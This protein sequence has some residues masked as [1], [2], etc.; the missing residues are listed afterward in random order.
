[1]EDA[2]YYSNLVQ[3]TESVQHQS[4]VI[5]RHVYTKENHDSDF[6]YSVSK[7]GVWVVKDK[8]IWLNSHVFVVAVT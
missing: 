1:M 8:S 3:L 4:T 5:F 6:K 7:T 2:A